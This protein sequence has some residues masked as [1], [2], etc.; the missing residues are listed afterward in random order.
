MSATGSDLAIGCCPKAGGT[1]LGS[2]NSKN[3][4]WLAN[5]GRSKKFRIISSNNSARYC[6]TPPITA[7]FTKS[8]FCAGTRGWLMLAA[9]HLTP[10]RLPEYLEAVEKFRPDF[11]HAYPSAALHLAEYV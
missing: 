4:Q 8:V 3:S 1:A 6:I 9:Y 11:I 2:A 7:P 10:E 5:S